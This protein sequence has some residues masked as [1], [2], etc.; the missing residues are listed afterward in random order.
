MRSF[1]VGLALGVFTSTLAPC[2]T[3]ALSHSD[4]VFTEIIRYGDDLGDG[5]LIYIR[6]PAI[7]NRGDV[8][9]FAKTDSGIESI[10][11]WRS[12]QF[13]RIVH[14]SSS[15]F[16]A[17]GWA[18]SINDS[19]LVAFT[20]ETN[21]GDIGIFTTT[22]GSSVTTIADT[23][24]SIDQ[25]RLHY[26]CNLSN[27]VGPSLNNSGQVAFWAKASGQEKIFLGDGS[28]TQEVESVSASDYDLC[29][30]PAINDAGHVV[31]I[32]AQYMGYADLRYW[33]GTVGETIVQ[34]HIAED[35]TPYFSFKGGRGNGHLP[36]L[37]DSDRVGFMAT[38][39][40]RNSESVYVF[41]NDVVTQVATNAGTAFDTF[42]RPFLND[43][44]G[45]I[46]NSDLNS[47]SSGIFTG[48]D[49]VL[50]CVAKTGDTILG[51]VVNR[52]RIFRGGFNDHGH[53]VFESS[54]SDGRPCGLFLAVPEPST[55][56]LAALA[57]LSLAF[58]SYRRRR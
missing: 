10:Y 33:D 22:D 43:A 7:N 17:F 53:V 46:F 25:L 38:A 42:E 9:F 1:L 14:N 51:S 56:A 45:I 39:S 5:A 28:T 47:S 3:F 50:D 12:G 11:T 32:R 36:A 52:P 58:Y 49:P 2:A 37:D 34:S 27:G 44:G 24:G 40:D 19:G 35:K 29:V 20:A 48:P 23:S 57:L 13:R 26:A 4:Y 55:L 31:Y 8:V 41:E 54:F 15:N 6:Q 30:R 18:A 21:A 16:S